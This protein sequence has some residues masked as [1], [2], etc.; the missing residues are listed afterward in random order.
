MRES[1]GQ[2]FLF[3]LIIVIIVVIMFILIGAMAYSKTYKIKT[4]IVD[5]V[6]KYRGYTGEAKT[7]IEAYLSS[8]G[9][10]INQNA[11]QQCRSNKGQSLTNTST[12]YHYCVY[13]YD[14]EG[15]NRG[16]YYGVTTYIYFE[17]PLIGDLIEIPIYG[18]TEVFYD[19]TYIE[20]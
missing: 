4:K 9:Y 12:I 2:A 5:I 6:E 10:K 1:I 19:E 14:S 11:T 8:I 20:G 16:K 3:N 7:E 17:F 15:I 18:E 13:E